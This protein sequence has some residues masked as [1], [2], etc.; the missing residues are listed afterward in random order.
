MVPQVMPEKIINFLNEF[1]D[2]SELIDE[3]TEK[4]RTWI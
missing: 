3:N 1:C 2:L 4:S